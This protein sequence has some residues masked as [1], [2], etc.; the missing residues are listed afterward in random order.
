MSTQHTS[1]QLDSAEKRVGREENNCRIKKRPF[2]FTYR[3]REIQVKPIE[4]QCNAVSHYMVGVK[5]K[6]K[7]CNIPSHSHKNSLGGKLE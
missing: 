3:P 2:C 6:K 5:K 7:S 4:A 1:T